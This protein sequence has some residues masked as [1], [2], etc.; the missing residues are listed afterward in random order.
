M[1]VQF[2]DGTPGSDAWFWVVE[3]PTAYVSQNPFH[4]YST[5]GTHTVTLDA[6]VSGVDCTQDQITVSVA[7][8]PTPGPTGTPGP[9]ATPTATPAPTPTPTPRTCTVPGLIGERKNAAQ[10]IWDAAGFTTTVQL[11]PG[12]HP[13]QNWLI[14]SQS[15]NSGVDA[16]CNVTIVIG[17]DPV[18]TPAP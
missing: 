11:A 2:N 14:E 5:P 6:D 18:P 13:S 8:T 4:T 17:P 1:D 3:G 15:L 12:A 7:P 9:T 10:G 16:A